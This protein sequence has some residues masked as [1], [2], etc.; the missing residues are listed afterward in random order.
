VSLTELLVREARVAA[1]SAIIS[2]SARM[3]DLCP[4]IVRVAERCVEVAGVV[5]GVD[6]SDSDDDRWKAVN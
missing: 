6:L 2:I 4:L 1:G 5:S 3:L